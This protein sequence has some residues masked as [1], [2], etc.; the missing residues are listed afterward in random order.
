MTH[1]PYVIC[2][3]LSTIFLTGSSM[4]QSILGTTKP[5]VNFYGKLETHQGN[6]YSVEN[7]TINSM[8]RQIPVYEVPKITTDEH[9]LDL[10]KGYDKAELDLAEM[11]EIAVP[12]QQAI[13]TVIETRNK[14]KHEKKFIEIQVTYKDKTERHYLIQENSKIG[15]DQIMTSGPIEIEKNISIIAIKTLN[16]EGFKYRDIGKQQEQDKK[17]TNNPSK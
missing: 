4:Q 3:I 15:C 16:I 1:K 17:T 2:A 8:F 10:A 5:N 9:I 6:V 11:S 7:I 14:R 13:W 12:N